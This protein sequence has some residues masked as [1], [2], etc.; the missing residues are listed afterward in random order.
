VDLLDCVPK[1]CVRR[2]VAGVE[3][4]IDERAVAELAV[5]ERDGAAGRV[6]EALLREL[7]EVAFVFDLV[8][9]RRRG[10]LRRD[11]MSLEELELEGQL[12]LL[13]F[14]WKIDSVDGRNSVWWEK[15]GRKR[16]GI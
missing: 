8:H 3:P 2:L 5:T 7:L 9:L 1:A 12:L 13:F 6:R 4:A 10:W 16:K 15:G 14:L 11:I